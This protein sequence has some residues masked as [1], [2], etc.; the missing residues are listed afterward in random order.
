VFPRTP[1]QELLAFDITGYFCDVKIPSLASVKSFLEGLG[2][3]FLQKRFPKSYFFKSALVLNNSEY[4]ISQDKLIHTIVVILTDVIIVQ[5]ASIGK[6]WQQGVHVA[7]YPY[8]PLNS[9]ALLFIENVRIFCHG[10]GFSQQLRG[11]VT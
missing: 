6:C 2:E 7:W 1:S 9:P 4:V 11:S 3:P 8:Q 10:R 5:K